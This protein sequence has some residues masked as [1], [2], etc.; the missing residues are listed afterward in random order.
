MMQLV[1]IN[2]NLFAILIYLTN[3]EQMMIKKNHN[4]KKFIWAININV[5]VHKMVNLIEIK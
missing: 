3:L 5:L 4:L 1:L 2:K